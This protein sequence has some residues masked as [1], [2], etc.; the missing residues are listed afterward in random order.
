[1]A[2]NTISLALRQ[3]IEVAPATHTYMNR[4]RGKPVAA[5]MRTRR[6]AFTESTDD[7]NKRAA[8]DE[9][10]APAKRVTVEEPPQIREAPAQCIG[11]AC[12]DVAPGAA[13][14]QNCA[15]MLQ[16]ANELSDKYETLKRNHNRA[17][18]HAQVLMGKLNMAEIQNRQLLHLGEC[19]TYVAPPQVVQSTEYTLLAQMQQQ[20]DMANHTIKMLTDRLHLRA[21]MADV[22]ERTAI[23]PQ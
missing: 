16:H 8:V 13:G 18:I 15:M 21:L 3:Y 23:K 7:G 2:S 10:A 6:S 9:C 4:G 12:V 5:A 22:A 1:M 14:C 19:R 11:V 20:L 17:L